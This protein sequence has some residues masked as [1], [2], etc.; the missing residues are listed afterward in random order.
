MHK[1]ANEIKETFLQLGLGTL[2][3][4]LAVLLYWS[5]ENRHALVN[6]TL[7]LLVLAVPYVATWIVLK[8]L[9]DGQAF[10]TRC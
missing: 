8:R 6:R 5:V 3:F 10:H 4:L 1:E 2:G 7:W 9:E